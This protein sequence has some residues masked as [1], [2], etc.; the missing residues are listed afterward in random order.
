MQHA[1]EAKRPLDVVIA[2]NEP[3]PKGLCGYCVHIDV[4]LDTANARP[5]ADDHEIQISDRRPSS[6]NSGTG[7]HHRLR[8]YS[9]SPLEDRL[10]GLLLGRFLQRERPLTIL[11]QSRGPGNRA[12]NTS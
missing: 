5:L 11:S 4:F 7:K 9:E 1:S 3:R 2:G 10:G 8:A 12:G 6:T